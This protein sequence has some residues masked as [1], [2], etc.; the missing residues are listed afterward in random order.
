MNENN[1]L[2]L[3]LAESRIQYLNERVHMKPIRRK[4]DELKHE[5]DFYK[6]F[7]SDI[8][9][10]EG[11][12]ERWAIDMEDLNKRI[13]FNKKELNYFNERYSIVLSEFRNN[14]YI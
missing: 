1:I 6:A 13:N 2:D 5:D 8:N 10:N 14:N 3:I 4:I 7:I 9:Y 12:A 11:V